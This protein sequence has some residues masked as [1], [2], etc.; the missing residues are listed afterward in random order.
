MISSD[1]SE[2]QIHR[3]LKVIIGVLVKISREGE[4]NR[5]CVCVCVCVCRREVFMEFLLWH[6][7]IGA[8]SVM[9]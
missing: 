5:V 2:D 4:K 3:L 1:I 7:M 9:C 6:Y 8:I